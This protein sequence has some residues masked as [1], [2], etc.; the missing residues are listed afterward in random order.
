MLRCVLEFL[1][2][3]A[4]QKFD[5]GSSRPNLRLP[6]EDGALENCHGTRRGLEHEGYMD[7]NVKRANSRDGRMSGLFSGLNK[8]FPRRPRVP[9]MC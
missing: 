9:E 3:N 8:S 4:P 5:E 2:G 7:K 1:Q 6:G